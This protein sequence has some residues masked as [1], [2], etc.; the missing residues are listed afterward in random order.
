VI[1]IGDRVVTTA[2][3]T[4]VYSEFTVAPLDRLIVVPRANASKVTT[5]SAASAAD[6]ALSGTSA[7]W[8]LSPL[9]A[10]SIGVPYA[11]AY[12]AL[13]QRARLGDRDSAT[14]LVHGGSGAVG[15]AAVQLAKAAGH[16]VF[17]TASSDRGL[18]MLREQGA[19]AIRHLRGD[20]G[21][22]V[23]AAVT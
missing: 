3:R 4:G 9:Q 18:S 15:V 7:G 19:E 13:F 10:A 5:A 16:H 12:R 14:V 1:S 11:T 23:L 8:V 22:T 20:G 6:G 17:A 2:S 21:A